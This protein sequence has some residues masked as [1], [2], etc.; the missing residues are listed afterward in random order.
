MSLFDLEKMSVRAG[1]VAALVGGALALAT[2]AYAQDDEGVPVTVQV[3]DTEGNP[4]PTAVVRH[5]QE[6]SRHRVNTETGK[7]TD[8]VLYL[9]NGD[10]LVFEKGM[11]LEFEISAPGYQNARVKYFVRKRKNLVPVVLQKMELDLTEDEE[12]DDPVIQFG[13]DKPID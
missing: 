9:P 2:P 1:V 6:E 8:S 13:R 4:V 11:E 5:P 7:W 10:E 3:L 12:M